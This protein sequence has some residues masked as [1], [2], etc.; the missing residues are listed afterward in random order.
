MF[1]QQQLASK[2]RLV[3]TEKIK[4]AAGGNEAKEECHHNYHVTFCFFFFFRGWQV[5]L[6]HYPTPSLLFRFLPFQPLQEN[7]IKKK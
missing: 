5:L 7:R 6:L 2:S 1:L 4:G 3:V